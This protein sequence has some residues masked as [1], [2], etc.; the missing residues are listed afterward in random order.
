M[1]ETELICLLKANTIV[2]S[3]ED[4]RL[5]NELDNCP[6]KNAIRIGIW[7]ITEDGDII[8][9][10]PDYPIWNYQINP[11]NHGCTLQHWITHLRSKVWFTKDVEH[12]FI[13]AYIIS[14]NRQG[15]NIYLK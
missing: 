5:L 13:S 3:K 11:Q 7:I 15:Y 6:T 1:N 14:C 8:S 10:E 4:I 12:D 2:V 9:H